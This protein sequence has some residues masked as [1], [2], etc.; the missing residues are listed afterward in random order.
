MIFQR[1]TEEEQETY[2]YSGNME[3]SN[4]LLNKR[5]DSKDVD[6]NIASVTDWNNLPIDELDPKFDYELHKV[7][8]E[9]DVPHADEE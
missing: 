3:Q 7:I 4:T 6:I 2:E 1:L 8:S 5:L 9:D